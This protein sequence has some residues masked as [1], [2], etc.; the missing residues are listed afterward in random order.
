[1]SMLILV[2]IVIVI[3]IIPMIKKK[4]G[5]EA[6]VL[7]ILGAITLAYGYYYNTHKYTASLV[8][9]MFELFNVR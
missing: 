4:Q 8:N 1:M 7:L 6:V 9:M 2:F 3:E 5:K